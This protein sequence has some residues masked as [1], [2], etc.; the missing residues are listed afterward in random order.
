MGLD[1][2]RELAQLDNVEELFVN[3]QCMKIIMNGKFIK[4]MIILC[5]MEQ[6]SEFS[7]IGQYMRIIIIYNWK[8]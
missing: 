1:K 7:V 8:S 6:I 3:K 4:I 5:A 2:V